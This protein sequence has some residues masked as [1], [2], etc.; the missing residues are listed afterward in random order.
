MKLF[1]T[2]TLLSLSAVS[3]FAHSNDDHRV[4]V[5]SN[6][7]SALRLELETSGR[8]FDV[9]GINKIKGEVELIAS[10]DQIDELRARGLNPQIR[11]DIKFNSSSLDAGSFMNRALE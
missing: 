9:L 8:G 4:V 3:A 10:D 5:Q 6:D 2:I 11:P 1:V 7:P